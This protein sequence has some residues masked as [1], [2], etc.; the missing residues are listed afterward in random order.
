MARPLTLALAILNWYGWGSQPRSKRRFAALLVLF[1]LQLCCLA[2]AQYSVTLLL[3]IIGIF[4]FFALLGIF[5]RR[6][7]TLAMSILSMLLL[8]VIAAIL[9]GQVILTK[10][11]GPIVDQQSMDA[12][13]S[14]QVTLPTLAI[15]VQNWKCA[16]DVIIDSPEIPFTR[17]NLH[18]LRRLIGYGPDTF[19]ATSQLKFPDDLKSE[20]TFKALLINQPENHYLYLGVTMGILGLMA[21][22]WLLAVYFWMGLRLLARSKNRETIVLAAAFVA[23]IA[24]YCTHIFFN[25]SRIVPELVFWLVLGMTVALARIDS[26]GIPGESTT[27]ELTGVAQKPNNL[28]KI[29]SVLIIVIFV[30][31]GSGLTLPLLQANMKVRDGFNLWDKNQDLALVSFTEAT[32]IGPDQAIYH[33]FLGNLAF[34]MAGDNE[35]NAGIKSTLLSL[36]EVAGDTA[37]GLEPQLA[38][39]RYRL[40]DREMY[41][42]MKG[43]T[44]KKAYILY[45]YE[46]ADQLFPRNAV[47]L[48]KWALALIL[49]QDYGEAGLKLTESEN[50]DPHWAQTSYFKGLLKTHE[51]KIDEAGDLLVSPIKNKTDEAGGL[52]VLTDKN[53]LENINYFIK[54]CGQV[55]P[56]GEIGLVKDALGAYVQNSKGDWTGFALL[57][58][59]N[60]Y[61]DAPAEALD[62]FKE[63]SLLV[64]DE[65]AAVLAAIVD[66]SLGRYQDL[67][68]GAVEIIKQLMQR[69]ATAR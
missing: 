8:A 12:S 20:Y 55:A 56:Y 27:G 1:G 68:E 53:K 43:S 34:G 35:T 9:L 7:T 46:E 13:A 29:F 63:A 5:L 60:I 37:I 65:D 28:R 52:S 18:G 31:I 22:L 30:A 47:I 38:V 4:V 11:T 16:V 67:H 17:D 58:I 24:Q 36:S 45:L 26:T 54:F 6:R 69:A 32:L 59:T 14:D 66:G 42:V 21:F 3:F 19:I 39:W 33:D 48:N 2:L 57:G 51:G 64:P 40:A 44:E 25:P 50:S 15:R 62:A 10:N 49:M 61:S 23:V 41:W